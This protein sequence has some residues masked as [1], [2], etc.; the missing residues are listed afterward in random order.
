MTGFEPMVTTPYRP[1]S[2]ITTRNQ[3]IIVIE[4]GRLIIFSPPETPN[5]D[6]TSAAPRGRNACALT[7]ID[8]RIHLTPSNRGVRLHPTE[9]SVRGRFLGHAVSAAPT[10]ERF[11]AQQHTPFVGRA[12]RI[13]AGFL[14]HL[15]AV[16]RVAVGLG[17]A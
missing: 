12:D 4:S 13:R 3:P 2:D 5:A 17:V 14:P 1:I 15:S 9:L 8:K 10:G 16:D 11:H 6:Q 7:D